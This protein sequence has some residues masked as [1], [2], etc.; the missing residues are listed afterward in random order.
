VFIPPGVAHGFAALTD[1]TITYLV[2]NYYNPEDE[3][4]VAWDDPAIDADWGV[5]DPVLSD[6]DKA[7]PGRANLEA[8][9][10]PHSG[11]RT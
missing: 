4:G 7:N 10:R 9:L 2:D 1:M 11:L 3:L 5:T 8:R 6:R